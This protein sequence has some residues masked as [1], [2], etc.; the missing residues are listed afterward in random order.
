MSKCDKLNAYIL[1]TT[2]SLSGQRVYLKNEADVVIANLEAENE[3]LKKEPCNDGEKC[4]AYW[5]LFAE[6]ERLKQEK[7]KWKAEAERWFD[8]YTSTEAFK[9]LAIAEDEN[10]RLNDVVGGG[11]IINADLSIE[12]RS[13]RRALWLTRAERALSNALIFYFAEQDDL[14][15]NIRGYAQ[16]EEGANRMLEAKKWYKIWKK[17]EKLCRAKAEEYK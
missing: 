12:L 4:N 1:F 9:K 7:D 15:L 2:S 5:K 10:L 3:R 13:T 14:D 6:N 17:V 16:K 11:D 8:R